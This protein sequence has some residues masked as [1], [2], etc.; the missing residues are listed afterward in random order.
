MHLG[1]EK[2]TNI[3]HT[4]SKWE[5]VFQPRNSYRPLL[6]FNFLRLQT[7]SYSNEHYYLG[8]IKGER[9]PTSSWS[10]MR[11]RLEVPWHG[12]NSPNTLTTQFNS[13]GDCSLNQSESKVLYC[14][15]NY[16]SNTCQEK[17]IVATYKNLKMERCTIVESW[18]WETNS[19]YHLSV[20][21]HSSS[22]KRE[23]DC[24]SA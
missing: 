15:W 5:T 1:I 3:L 21:I 8:W 20:L 4:P 14:R 12:L 7:T 16:S 9:P 24:A 2:Q 11:M 19:H 13:S 22:M 17:S 18:F 23:K 10:R 6:A